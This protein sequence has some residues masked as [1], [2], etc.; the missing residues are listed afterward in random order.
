MRRCMTRKQALW[1]TVTK[2]LHKLPTD[3]SRLRVGSQAK[4][5]YR[6]AKPIPCAQFLGKGG[7]AL[8]DNTKKR[9][10]HDF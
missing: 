10:W 7:S 8:E 6:F 5:S 2:R 1:K 4:K 3:P 9:I